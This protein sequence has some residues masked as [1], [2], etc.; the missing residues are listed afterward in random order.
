EAYPFAVIDRENAG[1]DSPE[2]DDTPLRG[3]AGLTDGGF[4]DFT[5]RGLFAAA[6]GR[7]DWGELAAVF[8]DRCVALTGA[9]GDDKGFRRQVR[10][11]PRT[12]RTLSMLRAVLETFIVDSRWK[13]ARND[14]MDF[15]HTIVPAVYCEHVLLDKKWTDHADRARRKLAEAG[16]NRPLAA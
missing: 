12:G 4:G 3:L 13:P 10:K 9:C 11:A 7:L 14:V 8:I 5:A 2:S 15:F 6:R 16:D 1:A